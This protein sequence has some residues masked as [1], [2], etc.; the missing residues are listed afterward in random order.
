M[1]KVVKRCS[2]KLL[3]LTLHAFSLKKKTVFI[4]FIV[5]IIKNTLSKNKVKIWGI[6]AQ[7]IKLNVTII[8]KNIQNDKIIIHLPP[9]RFFIKLFSL[10]TTHSHAFTHKTHTSKNR[11]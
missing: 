11:I 2:R 4:F 7:L 5:T 3:Q 6:C 8:P 1:T 10:Y 9:R